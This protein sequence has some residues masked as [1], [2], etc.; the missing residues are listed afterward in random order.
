MWVVTEAIDPCEVVCS[1]VAASAHVMKANRMIVDV[2]LF[3]SWTQ[4][5]FLFLLIKF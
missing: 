3:I 2:L 1:I 4:E 5:S